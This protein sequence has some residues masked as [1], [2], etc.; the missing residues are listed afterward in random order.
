L[1]PDIARFMGQTMLQQAYFGQNAHITL[2]CVFQKVLGIT[3]L[4]LL[5]IDDGFDSAQTRF[6]L[7]RYR[8]YRCNID[9]GPTMAVSAVW[10]QDVQMRFEKSSEKQETSVVLTPNMCLKVVLLDMC[11]LFCG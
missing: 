5:S 2:R 3:L 1:N 6:E 8:E 9:F 7:I 4:K 10:T 11:T